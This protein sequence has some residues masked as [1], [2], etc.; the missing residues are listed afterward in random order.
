MVGIGDASVADEAGA[1]MSSQMMFGRIRAMRLPDGDVV[2]SRDGR[3][4]Q[5]RAMSYRL[6]DRAQA[7]EVLA[8]V[9]QRPGTDAA[10]ERRALRWAIEQLGGEGD[11]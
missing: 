11:Q 3:L 5:G 8:T 6:W 7:L 4:G 10:C 2:I 1:A 9:S